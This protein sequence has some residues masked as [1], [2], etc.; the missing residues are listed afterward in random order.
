M[1]YDGVETC[2]A[3]RSLTKAI[4]MRILTRIRGNPKLIDAVTL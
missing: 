1:V 3:G 4:A 2:L